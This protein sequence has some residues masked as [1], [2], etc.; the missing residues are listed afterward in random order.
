MSGDRLNTAD[1][2]QMTDKLAELCEEMKL[3]LAGEEERTA[4]LGLL[5]DSRRDEVTRA[6]ALLGSYDQM[7]AASEIL[8][9]CEAEEESIRQY[10]EGIRLINDA[11]EVREQYNLYHEAKK[12]VS[13]TEKELKEN[14]NVVPELAVKLER[15]REEEKKA[16]AEAE[17]RLKE[18]TTIKEKA[19]RSEQILKKAGELRRILEQKQL[20]YLTAKEKSREAKNAFR[21]YEEQEKEWRNRK[22]GLSDTD[23]RTAELKALIRETDMVYDEYSAVQ[24]AY[25]EYEAAAAEAAKAEED[26]ELSRKEYSQ[27]KAEYERKNEQ[28]LD[29]QAGFLAEKLEPGK[30]CPVCGSTEHPD[31]CVIRAE[32]E[33]VTRE[34]IEGLSAETAELE[35]KRSELSQRAGAAK[36]LLK[37]KSRFCTEA[38]ERAFSAFDALLKR[39]REVQE[40]SLPDIEK[41]TGNDEKQRTSIE[42]LEKIGILLKEEER[43]LEESAK[44][45]EEL[46][47]KLA[48][49]DENREKLRLEAEKA[50][51]EAEG[52]RV[53]AAA[54]EAGLR[55]LKDQAEYKTEASAQRAVSEAESR[56]TTSETRAQAVRERVSEAKTEKEKAETLIERCIASMP[57]LK[58]VMDS[59]KAGYEAVM[60]QK[61]LSFEQWREV[62]EMHSR[63]D[64][65]KYQGYID[66]HNRKRAAARSAYE[67]AAAAVDGSARPD[68][69]KLQEEEKEAAAAF[70]AS[71]RTLEELK[72]C[73]RIDRTAL[74]ALKA[75]T[76]ERVR[77]LDEF[78]R[79]DS[80]YERLA[81]KRTGARM[82]IETFVQRYYMKRVLR[83][84][85]RRF[86]EMSAGQYELRMTG[87]DMAGE[88]RNRGL[89]L[90]VYS[91]VTGK[92]REIKTLSGGE[93]FMAALSMALGMA[94]MISESSSSID[95][96]MM[97]I[98]EGF[99]S[100]DDNS[101][102]QAV[103]I[104]QQM[105][106]GSR[107]IGIISH[108]SELKQAIDNKLVVTKD[109][110]G[111]HAE[112]A[113]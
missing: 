59:R 44:E 6:R 12:A 91:A 8:R 81:G 94:D 5:R 92:E 93:S 95:L 108:V 75:H 86:S 101:R 53:E 35:Q 63:E 26:Y 83:A 32:H 47:K 43:R 10:S 111:S 40:I 33:G 76:G 49:T 30:P 17:E 36:E 4:A 77:V 22:A 85:N 21:A 107:L 1:I 58:A 51:K 113:R 19:Q 11:Y 31:P 61:R 42:Y 87:E 57:E 96:E 106:E 18:Y 78:V 99:G 98:D 46:R 27:K 34:I 2:E 56:K 66:E 38:S 72:S 69:E 74:K 45:L 29:A 73:L 70:D 97:F 90:M 82:D 41:E 7:E 88:G 48:N 103:R 13:E 112:W 24:N 102:N 79:I 109:A 71:V 52:S 28:F 9:K 55:G 67:T 65:S 54:A 50:A 60:E 15:L 80:L 89:D 20:E 39:L 84:A 68:M 100:L 110:W 25:L 64:A 16:A 3:R 14:R 37:E 104:L 62:V 105:A 23:R